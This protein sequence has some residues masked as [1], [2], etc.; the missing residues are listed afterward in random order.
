MAINPAVR[1]QIKR[2]FEISFVL[3]KEHIPFLKYP[4][5]HDLEE[6]HGVD[7]GTTYKNRDSA[8]NFVHYI[9]ESQ[10]QH[11]YTT[12]AS[13][14]FYSILMDSS[15][16]K[17][18]VEN[19]LFVILF[20][21]KDDAQLE[22]KTT[23][24][25]YCVLE[26]R[27]TDADG[28][29]EC[30]GTAL[31]G[32]GIDNLLERENVL[33][34]TGFP[35][36]I[37]C[38]TDGASVNVAEQNGMKG[39]LQAALP[40]LHWAWCYAH[41]LELACNDAFSSHL[42]HDIDEML[43][44]LYFLYEKSPKKC[45]DLSDLVGDLKEVYELPEGG[46]IPVRA[47][48]SRW[49]THKRKALQRLVDRY[50]AYLNHLAALTEDKSIKSTDR[51]RLK[52]YLL[53]WRQARMIIGSALYTDA[54][55]PASLLSLTLQDDDIDVVQGIK[56]ILKSHTSLK[57]LTS[58]DVVEWPVTKVVLS[59]LKDENGGKVYQ[60][61]EL[62]NFKDSTIKTCQDQALTDLK[63]LDDQMC[64]RLEWSDVDLMRSILLF[65]DTQ[66]WQLQVADESLEDDR[67]SEVK[68]ALVSITDMFR[69]PLEARHINI[70]SSL[71]EIEDIVEYARAYLRIGCESYKK[72]W[73]QLKASPDSVKWP[74]IFLITELLFSLPFS[75]A[76]V[77][78][79]FSIL[80]I[81]K[82]ERRASLNCSTLNDLLEVNVEGPTLK[83]FIPDSA[84]DIWWSS[85]QSGRRVNQKPRKE[86][87]RRQKTTENASSSEDSETE[88]LDIDKWDSWFGDDEQQ[89]EVSLSSD[90]HSDFSD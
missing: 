79:F 67:L 1:E 3:A 64:S 65:L 76:K 48:G 30:L 27:K 5:I 83:N 85:C 58:Q 14:H 49:I 18:R 66:S 35:V 23:A 81:I 7:L 4:A 56:N 19:E 72:I 41:R 69:A 34:V 61:S 44:R 39:K 87:R 47:S 8:R 50:G 22:L 80:K 25:Y 55:K 32:M 2:K 15:T 62:H 43:L 28:L 51:Q 78:R 6:R 20:C 53:K 38:G 29:V 31:K 33:S 75:T 11:L 90:S 84:V 46:N 37:G 63:S 52:G 10:R 57:K 26:P 82:N 77:E 70:T 42:F 74:N 71:D 12:L 73:Y 60:G 17:G 16:D 86:Y 24:R 68:A 21:Q 54:L 40:W 89:L 36:L 59:K 45:R 88:Q 13:R 9:A